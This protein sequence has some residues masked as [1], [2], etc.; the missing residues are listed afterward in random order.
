MEAAK[1]SGLAA[2]SF[3]ARFHGF[4]AREFS[5]AHAK[6]IP[7]AIQ[8]ETNSAAKRFEL[9]REGVNQLLSMV[10]FSH[11]SQNVVGVCGVSRV[12]EIGS[13]TYSVLVKQIQVRKTEGSRN[14][15]STLVITIVCSERRVDSLAK[16]TGHK[17]TTRKAFHFLKGFLSRNC[18]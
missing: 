15:D 16:F 12:R 8:A 11:G 10:S 17:F 5:T 13:K 14:G 18:C 1:T 7:P 2:R 4:V 3:L 9:L 6:K